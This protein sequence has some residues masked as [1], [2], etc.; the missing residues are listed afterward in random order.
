MPVGPPRWPSAT[1]AWADR[2][3]P[4]PCSDATPATDQAG[5]VPRR[6]GTGRWPGWYQTAIRPVRK[7]RGPRGVVADAVDLVGNIGRAVLAGPADP[8]RPASA[9][10]RSQIADLPPQRH[11]HGRPLTGA[12]ITAVDVTSMNPR[13][14][15]P[16][17]LL[18]GC[19]GRREHRIEQNMAHPRRQL[20]WP[21]GRPAGWR[22]PA[23]CRCRRRR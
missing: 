11:D 22:T 2:T 12:A 23:R 7:R 21:G 15:I 3:G 8:R 13:R 5:H 6:R 18:G 9:P 20:T 10:A 19:P 14:R 16:E 1:R 17:G 4:R